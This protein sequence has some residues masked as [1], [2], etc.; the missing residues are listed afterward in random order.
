MDN[1]IEIIKE[2]GRCCKMFKRASDDLIGFTWKGHYFI[3]IVL[4]MGLK[5]SAFFVKG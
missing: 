1:F 4:P 5:S 2:K 3:D